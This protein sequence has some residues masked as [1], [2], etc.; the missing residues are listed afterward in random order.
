MYLT[1]LGYVFRESEYCSDYGKNDESY[2][3][4]NITEL[5]ES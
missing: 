3:C 1:K 2:G 5:C 4:L